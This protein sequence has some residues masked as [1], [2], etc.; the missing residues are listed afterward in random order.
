MTPDT[1]LSPTIA[2]AAIMLLG[3]LTA[4]AGD[5]LL[6]RVSHGEADSSG[7]KIHYASLGEGP[8]VLMIHGFPDY[9][10]T[11]RHQMQA[12]AQDFQVVAMDLRGY[13]RSGQPK[14]VESYAMP[15]ML[16]DVL[17][18]LDH[19][20]AEKGAVVG[21]DWGGAI[22]WQFALYQPDRTER[23]VIL[24]LPHPRGLLRELAHNPVQRKNS[25][26]AQKFKASDPS[27]PTV[28]FGQPMTAE[29]L[30]AWVTDPEARRHYVEAFERSSFDGMLAM[31]KANYPGLPEPDTPMPEI[32]KLQMPVLMF[33]GL[34]DWALH[35]D[36]LNGTWDWLEKDLTLVT[37][38]GASHFVQQDA[39]QLVS[40]TMSWW[41]KSERMH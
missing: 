4:Y 10:Y 36:G 30:A 15:V 5:S 16:G 28:L 23:L 19:L 37:V 8:V 12:L 18:V 27:D 6:D 7:V 34:D 22:A 2:L 17:A 9:W 33:H 38:P 14:G 13:N 39:P 35:S 29:N 11:W 31:Y 1:S 21:H 40:D 20:G 41:L 26:Y 25:A 3:P 24:N 32:P